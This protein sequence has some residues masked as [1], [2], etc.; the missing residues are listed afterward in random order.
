MYGNSKK[1]PSK[2]REQEDYTFSQNQYEDYLTL[3]GIVNRTGIAKEDSHTFVLKELLDNAVDDVE[4]SDNPL[5]EAEISI[6]GSGNG[7][8][9]LK[10][11]SERAVCPAHKS[12][13]RSL[14]FPL[15]A[16]SL[17]DHAARTVQACAPELRRR[18]KL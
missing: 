15:L 11:P 13:L 18:E 7:Y 9:C 4:K 12:W 16:W 2:V 10:T 6:R 14:R 8:R 3:N 1:L 5:V 17:Q